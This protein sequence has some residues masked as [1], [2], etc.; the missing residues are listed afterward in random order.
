MKL[1]RLWLDAAVM[2]AR[3]TTS[4]QYVSGACVLL[5][6]YQNTDQL[7]H[8]SSLFHCLLTLLSR[9]CLAIS[10]SGLGW[11]SAKPFAVLPLYIR[12]SKDSK[13]TNALAT[14][15][16]YSS[17]ELQFLGASINPSC[18][19]SPSMPHRYMAPA[20]WTSP[21]RCM[22]MCSEGLN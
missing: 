4:P 5:Q 12:S 3:S 16:Q 18:E 7:V 15:L 14:A 1:L 13:A 2:L 21:R 19:G 9:H 20:A 8:L 10:L 17:D 11:V 6:R 22:Q